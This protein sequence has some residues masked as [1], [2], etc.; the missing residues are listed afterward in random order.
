MTTSEFREQFF[1]LTDKAHRIV[2][3][4]HI[5]PDDDSIGSVLSI[6]AI[7]TEKYPEKDIRIIYTGVSV[8][9]YKVFQGFSSIHWVDDVANHL[10]GIDTLIT[11]D[12]SNWRRFSKHEEILAA[13]P[14]RIGL[15]HHASL[16]DEYTLLFKDETASSNTELIYRVFLEGGLLSKEI[17][18]YVLLGVLGDTANFSHVKPSHAE[19]LLLGKTL[20]ETVGMPIDQ[21]RSRYGSI[22]L[23]IIPLLQELVKNTTYVTVEGWPPVQYTFADRVMATAANYTDEEMSAASHIYMGQYLPRVEGYGWGF[24]VTPRSDGGCRQSG[25]SLPTSVN[26]RDFHEKLGIGSGHDRAAGGYVQEPDPKAWAEQVL[27]WM[28]ENKPLIG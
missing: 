10:E 18:E 24:V 26:V 6:Y 15:D 5:S 8:D 28:K 25:R 27:E 2:I 22:P 7:L 23:R 1:A 13:I 4:S 16:P 12:A 3:T 19:T 9:R 11:L 17:A 14:V 21:F 20:I